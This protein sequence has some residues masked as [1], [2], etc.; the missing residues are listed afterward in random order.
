M[1][2]YETGKFQNADSQIDFLSIPPLAI[3]WRETLLL[4][5][6]LKSYNPLLGHHHFQGAA[7]SYLSQPA[8]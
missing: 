1:T 5:S 3:P 2:W 4:L 7:H 8:N 6:F